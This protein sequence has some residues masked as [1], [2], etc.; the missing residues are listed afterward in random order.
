MTLKQD[1]KAVKQIN[2]DR[3]MNIKSV[4][5]RINGKSGGG[6][7]RRQGPG[8]FGICENDGR[9]GGLRIRKR[10][11]RFEVSFDEGET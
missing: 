10:K 2:P 7:L 8:G 1:V 9:D 5:S 6:S 11:S 4:W 3:M